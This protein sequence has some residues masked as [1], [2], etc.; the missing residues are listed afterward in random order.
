MA[1]SV[2]TQR[3]PRPPAYHASGR[4]W[5][6]YSERVGAAAAAAAVAAV[7]VLLHLHGRRP[8]A[9]PHLLQ[10]ARALAALWFA[11]PPWEAAV[12]PARSA[13]SWPRLSTEHWRRSRW[14]AAAAQVSAL[15]A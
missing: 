8:R 12:A 6:R 1:I 15:P 13:G 7:S 2:A 9:T 10:Q 14:A 11:G 4:H 3:R 5:R